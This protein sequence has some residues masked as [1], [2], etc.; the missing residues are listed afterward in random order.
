MILYVV[1]HGIA[2][3]RDDPNCPP[4]TD[5]YLT[6]DGIKKTREVAEGVAALKVKPSLLITSPYVRSAQTA[7]IFAE[8]LGCAREKIKQ[9]QALRPGSNPADFVK[10]IAHLK[11]GEIMCFGHAPHLDQVIAAAVGARGVFTALKKAGV[12]ALEFESASTG[13]ATLLWILTPKILRQMKE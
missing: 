10:E 3:E 12:A 9:S 1:R 4:E 13:K 2:I 11:A 6:R 7:E 8:A 5:R